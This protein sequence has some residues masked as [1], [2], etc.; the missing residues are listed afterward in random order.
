M[1]G[2]FP[3]KPVW[4]DYGKIEIIAGAVWFFSA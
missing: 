3:E 4:E 2:I 1:V